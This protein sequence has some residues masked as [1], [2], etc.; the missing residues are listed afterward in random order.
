MGRG[1]YLAG[2]ESRTDALANF[3]S[4]LLL[5]TPLRTEVR[6]PAARVIRRLRGRAATA[7]VHTRRADGRCST[8]I[9]EDPAPISPSSDSAPRNEWPE[10]DARRHESLCQSNPP[11]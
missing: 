7:T 1:I 6:A 5:P 2:C 10:P 3:Q 8:A 11:A 9:H 4:L